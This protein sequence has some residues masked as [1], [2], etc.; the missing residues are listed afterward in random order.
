MRSGSKRSAEGITIFAFPAAS[1]KVSPAT[2]MT[3]Y[4]E[5]G[6]ASAPFLAL[7]NPVVRS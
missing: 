6:Y 2:R 5:M 4:I 7:I 3:P 1:G